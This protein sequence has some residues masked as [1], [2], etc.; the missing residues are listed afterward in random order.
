MWRACFLVALS[1]SGTANA[2][3]V[4]FFRFPQAEQAAQVQQ[5]ID[6]VPVDQIPADQAAEQAADA[7]DQTPAAGGVPTEEATEKPA[8][9]DGTDRE[10]AARAEGPLGKL[11]KEL[12]AMEKEIDQELANRSERVDRELEIVEQYREEQLREYAA[13]EKQLQELR[14]VQHKP[15]L[16][17]KDSPES[18][19]QQQQKRIVLRYGET[20]RVAKLLEA[21]AQSFDLLQERIHQFINTKEQEF[22]NLQRQQVDEQAIME[23]RQR[24]HGLMQKMHER[25]MGRRRRPNHHMDIHSALQ[26]GFVDYTDELRAKLQLPVRSGQAGQLPSDATGEREQVEH[27]F[28]DLHAPLQLIFRLRWTGNRVALD[29][30]HWD[31]LFGG[32]DVENVRRGV[33]QQ[34][35]ERGIKFDDVEMMANR[36]HLQPSSPLGMLVENLQYQ[37]QK[38]SEHGFQHHGRTATEGVWEHEFR[39]NSVRW[40]VSVGPGKLHVELA[41]LSVPAK[42]LDVRSYENGQLQISLVGNDFFWLNQAADGSVQIAETFQKEMLY[43][44]ADSMLALYAAHPTYL[45][46]N[47]FPRLAQLGIL[48][49]PQRYDTPVIRQVLR[50]IEAQSTGSDVPLDTLVDQLNSPRYEVREVA[51][52]ALEENLPR[53]YEGLREKYQAADIP[54]EVRARIQRLLQKQS[55][56]KNDGSAIVDMLKLSE[57]ARYLVE[58][59]PRVDDLAQVLL[60]THLESLTG[61]TPEPN[62]EAWQAWLSHQSRD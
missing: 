34:L 22:Q 47:V 25:R 23:L 40:R 28:G 38:T 31:A 27:D 2:Q 21:A 62:V 14:L 42:T 60:M 54:F 55:A 13:T 3:R 49:P 44:K 48:P 57:D 37:A 26:Q 4:P 45:E 58:I 15:G 46:S 36:Y 56:R 12:E 53:Y 51:A 61:Q 59:L 6:I 17:A 50:Q 33:Q 39:H 5:A 43:R 7:A 32:E 19:L 9:T 10:P 35:T 16:S 41:D 24:L 20:F 18:D 11:R 8:D 52:K 30:Q 29:E 1:L